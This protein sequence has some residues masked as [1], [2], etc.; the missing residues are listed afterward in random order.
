MNGELKF[1]VWDKKSLCW[2]TDYEN[3]VGKN[4]LKFFIDLTGKLGKIIY[5]LNGDDGSEDN[6]VNIEDCVIQQY[7]GLVDEN[8]VE[9]Y[10]GDIIKDNWKEN[11]P[12]G[13]CPDEWYNEEDIFVVRYEPPSFIFPK[14]RGEQ[15]CIEDFKRVVVGNIF[16]NPELL[17]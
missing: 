17:K 3:V 9:I 11:H 2:V 15:R 10:E 7:T 6:V 5:P 16:E 13:Y 12:Y 14:R 8:N 1:R 4:R